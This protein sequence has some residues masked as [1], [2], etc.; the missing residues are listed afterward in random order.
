MPDCSI[1]R[2]GFAIEFFYQPAPGDSG[3]NDNG[4]LK[5]PL[6]APQK[7]NDCLFGYLN[8]S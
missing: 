3:Q 1:H 8:F 2:P 5:R 7:G 6:L 4:R